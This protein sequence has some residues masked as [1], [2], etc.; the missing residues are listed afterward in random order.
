M[1]LW[2]QNYSQMVHGGTN[3]PSTNLNKICTGE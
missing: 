1:E 2:T 3:N